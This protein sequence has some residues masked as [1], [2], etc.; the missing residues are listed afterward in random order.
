MIEL[1]KKLLRLVGRTNAKHAMIEDGDRVLL[2]LSGGKDSLVLAHILNHFNK[3]SPTNWTYKAVTID[4]GIGQDFSYL[5]NHTKTHGINYEVVHTNA[6]EIMQEKNR[7]NTTICSFCARMRRGH[8][9]TYALENGFNKLALGHHLDDAVESFFMNFTYNG[10]L[11][12][13]APKYRAEN[14]LTIIRPLIYARERQIMDCTTK[15]EFEVLTDEM[16]PAYKLKEKMP[17]ARAEAKELLAGLESANPKLFVSLKA[18]F[19]NIHLDT[20]FY[21]NLDDIK[22]KISLNLKD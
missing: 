2:G 13:L 1:S 8:L 22:D 9:Y 20:F 12:T 17:K 18:A 21:E 14:G 11:R 5:L 3:V 10:A 16:C 4:Y 19:E 15:N 7:K 6:F